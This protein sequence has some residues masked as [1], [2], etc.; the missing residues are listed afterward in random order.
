MRHPVGGVVGVNLQEEGRPVGRGS[1]EP[2]FWSPKDLYILSALPF[3]S[4]TSLAAIE[5]HRCP[6]KSG[7]SYAALFTEDQRGTRA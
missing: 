3:G 4:G 6:N 5:N 7:C 1:L 2:T